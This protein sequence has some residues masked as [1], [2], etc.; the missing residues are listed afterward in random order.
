[1]P[2]SEPRLFAFGI[3]ER[4]DCWTSGVSH[5]HL[6]GECRQRLCSSQCTLRQDGDCSGEGG[7]VLQQQGEADLSLVDLL[8][9]LSL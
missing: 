3:G 5:F 6:G 4:A 1:M 2:C 8:Q 9:A 7:A